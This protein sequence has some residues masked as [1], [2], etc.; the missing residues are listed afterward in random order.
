MNL[1]YISHQSK[2]YEHFAYKMVYMIH[3]MLKGN[4]TNL[5]NLVHTTTPLNT[6]YEIYHF[7]STFKFTTM[8]MLK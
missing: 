3:K 1:D 5:T 2:E 4:L 6:T 7:H 8:L